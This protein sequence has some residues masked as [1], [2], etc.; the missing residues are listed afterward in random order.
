MRIGSCLG[1]FIPFNF[2]VFI[3]VRPVDNQVGIADRQ[4]QAGTGTDNGPETAAAGY[5]SRSL[6][7]YTRF[8]SGIRCAERV[9]NGR[10]HCGTESTGGIAACIGF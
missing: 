5:P 8:L 7:I 4:D 10:N 9:S 1:R 2:T 3:T 6:N